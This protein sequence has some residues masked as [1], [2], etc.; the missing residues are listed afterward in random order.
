MIRSKRRA[1]QEQSQMGA[2]EMAEAVSKVNRMEEELAAAQAR[3]MEKQSQIMA[4][5]DLRHQ[6]AS[7]AQGLRFRVELQEK[8]IK[9]R[10]EGMKANGGEKGDESGRTLEGPLSPPPP[11]EFIKII[12]DVRKNQ[13][14][15]ERLI[16]ESRSEEDRLRQQ[17]DEYE[18]SRVRREENIQE[19]VLR[20]RQVSRT[21]P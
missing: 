11:P 16:A 9:D 4:E 13:K 21:N 8:E 5:A 1:A 20:A 17:V 6:R 10:R 2:S 7:L 12:E 18:A 14:V 3:L 19:A 15:L